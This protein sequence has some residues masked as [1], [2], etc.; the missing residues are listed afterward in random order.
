MREA[1]YKLIVQGIRRH[2]GSLARSRVHI[3]S[4]TP[5]ERRWFDGGPLWQRHAHTALWTAGSSEESREAKGDR[6]CPHDEQSHRSRPPKIPGIMEPPFFIHAPSNHACPAKETTGIASG[7]DNSSPSVE[8]RL[9]HQFSQ[10]GFDVHRPQTFDDLRCVRSVEID[11]LVYDQ[12]QAENQIHLAKLVGDVDTTAGRIYVQEP[13]RMAIFLDRA[14]SDDDGSSQPPRG[15][16][17]GIASR[18]K[19]ER[20]EWMS[21]APIEETAELVLK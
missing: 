15:Q 3:G 2:Q 21:L 12:T 16:V 11:T 9:E 8:A 7:P 13:Q 1:L 19:K 18:P 5:C 6:R 20:D 4:Q 17:S 14:Q 10:V